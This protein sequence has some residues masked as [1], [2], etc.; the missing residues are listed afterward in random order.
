MKALLIRAVIV[1]MIFISNGF[2]NTFSQQ[3]SHELFKAVVGFESE[4]MS[5]M[6]QTL[7]PERPELWDKYSDCVGNLL[8]ANLY[9]NTDVEK[10]T[11][12]V[13]DLRFHKEMTCACIE[14]TSLLSLLNSQSYLS[15]D[16][17]MIF[18][19]LNI[20]DLMDDALLIDAP[21]SCDHEGSTPYLVSLLRFQCLDITSNPLKDLPVFQI[22]TLK[23]ADFLEGQDQ[24]FLLFKDLSPLYCQDSHSTFAPKDT[25]II[26]WAD[27][28]NIIEAKELFDGDTAPLKITVIENP[29]ATLLNFIQD[30][31]V[32]Y[33]N[34][35]PFSDK[36]ASELEMHNCNSEHEDFNTQDQTEDEDE[37]SLFFFNNPNYV[38]YD[39]EMAESI[40]LG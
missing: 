34:L 11:K 6:M 13:Y 7:A 12:A 14:N 15:S 3:T 19:M 33:L 10:I 30:H 35:P 22:P 40:N 31:F 1:I 20:V 32:S 37:S 39:D 9:L 38:S 24:A 17:H 25:D 28:D 36:L 26:Q 27:V 2:A 8:L 18:E 4:P 29:D 21:C 23:L 16:P 5:V